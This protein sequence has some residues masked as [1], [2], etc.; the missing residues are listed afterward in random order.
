M[1]DITTEPVKESCTGSSGPVR[2]ETTGDRAIRRDYFAAAALTGILAARSPEYATFPNYTATEAV[3]FADA[4]L[5]ELDKSP[6]EGKE[7]A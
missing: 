6:E 2:I 3:R 5:L 4:L 1:E 7:N